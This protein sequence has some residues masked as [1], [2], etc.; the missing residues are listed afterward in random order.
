M[1]GAEDVLGAAIER[2]K[3]S[4]LYEPLSV[5]S[6]T[7]AQEAARLDAA[8]N[9]EPAPLGE[10]AFAAARLTPTWELGRT[11][12]ES[13]QFPADPSYTPPAPDST[14]FRTMTAGI[15]AEYW[16]NFARA[17]SPQE[18]LFIKR[19]I[20]DELDAR[21]KLASGG[22]SSAALNVGSALLDPVTLAAVLGT[23]GSSL[24]VQGGRVARAAR[25]AALGAAQ[26][27]GIAALDYGLSETKDTSDIFPAMV[28]GLVLM[29]GAGALARVTPADELYNAGRKAVAGEPGMAV[30]DQ[31]AQTI[32]EAVPPLQRSTAAQE[33]QQT[34]EDATRSVGA[35]EATRGV[36]DLGDTPPPEV[37]NT[38]QLPEKTKSVE[39]ALR[40]DWYARLARSPNPFVRFMG[41]KLLADPVG[42]RDAVQE[43]AAEEYRRL[44]VNQALSKFAAPS[45]K[46]VDEALAG[47]SIAERPAATDAFYNEVSQRVA[48]GQ[49]DN[50]PLGRAATGMADAIETAAQAGKRQGIKGFDQFELRRTYVPRLPSWKKLDA[51]LT[52][53]GSQQV[54]EKLLGG[55]ITSGTGIEPDLA[56]KIAKGYIDGVRARDAGLQGDFSLTLADKDAVAE[57][58]RRA[59]IPSDQIDQV[60]ARLKAFGETQDGQ[61]GKMARAK[62]RLALDDTYKTMLTDQ[63]G[64][65]VPVSIMDMFETDARYLTSRY[66]S[67]VA[68]HAALARSGFASQAEWDAMIRAAKRYEKDRVGPRGTQFD[69]EMRWL[70][71]ARSSILGRP[72][73]DYTDSVNAALYAARDWA[74][75]AQSGAFWA[76]QGSELMTVLATGGVKMVSDLVPEMKGMFTRAAEGKLNSDVARDMEDLLAPGVEVLLDSVLGRHANVLE[77]GASN[78]ADALQKTYG[79]RHALKRLA[80]FASLLSPTTVFMQR[81]GAAFVAQRLV[82]ELTGTAGKGYSAMRLRSLGLSADMER[83]VAAQMKKTVTWEPSAEAGRTV[84]R[85]NLNAWTDLDARDAFALAVQREMDRLSLA[86]NMGAAIPETR[87]TEAGKVL[88]QFM[89]FTAQAHSR[90]L[91]HGIKHMDAERAAGWLLGMGMAGMLYV[92]RTYLESIGRKNREKYLA[93]RLTLGKIAAA[94]FSRAGFSSLMPNAYDTLAQVVPGLSPQFSYI[95]T[96]GLGT[97]MI[98][99]KNIPAGAEVAALLNVAGSLHDKAFTQQ[100][101]QNFQRLLPFARALVIQQALNKL[102]ESLP[103]K[104]PS[105]GQGSG[106]LAR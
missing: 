78:V 87:T 5:P 89:T 106:I 6:E 100:D 102:G 41:N 42:A 96:S 9:A 84:P 54:E 98:D 39:S 53:F 76:A 105:A 20:Q 55:S 12:F 23:G 36:R 72:L 18:A 59:E 30:A 70:D 24:M 73:I 38:P 94:G 101:W 22:W 57:L 45:A 86:P 60:L 58:M 92:A 56:A 33:A 8:A 26:G 37:L 34:I 3:T 29:G 51:L 67:T 83:R 2:A 11:L 32:D 90:L 1:N 95:R 27:G 21:T 44:V 15:P 25:M 82:N 48:A 28:G 61:G 97:S 63:A 81:T 43:A 68:G 62:R 47:V 49:F 80:G 46:A 74:F 17:R 66:V 75:I 40:F 19:S 69:K 50:T 4:P 13:T 16:T 71:A 65:K 7:A 85:L 52:R 10:R 64:N 79:V 99:P 104:A 31:L 93:D 35:Q 88:S 77:N 91:L 14:E 103:E